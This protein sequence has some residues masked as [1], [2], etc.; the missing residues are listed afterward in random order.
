M[1]LSNGGSR[2]PDVSIATSPN[3]LTSVPAIL[4]QISEQGAHFSTTTL[5]YEGR[6]KLLASARALVQALETP[7]ETMLKHIW[8]QPSVQVGITMLYNAG[9]FHFMAEK[10][11]PV[12]IDECAEATKMDSKLLARL[13]R[14]LG[15]MGYIIE[16]GVDEYAPTN[17]SKAMSLR[18]IGDGYPCVVNGLFNTLGKFGDFTKAHDNKMV[19][20]H[21]DTPLRYTEKTDMN[22]FTWLQSL[23]LGSHLNNHMAGYHQG[24]P[25]WMDSNI[26]P[27]DDRLIKGAD[28][29]EDAPFLVDIGGS[30]GHDLAEFLSKHPGHPGKLIL[31]D[32]P[33]VINHI[34]EL[35]QRIEPVPY[36]FHTT[37]PYQGA[38][39]Y[40][41]HSVLHDWP[42]NICADI[43]KNVVA[44]MAPGYSRLLINE[45]VIP[46]RGADWQATALDVMIMIEFSSAERTLADWT[47]LLEPAGL[48]IIQV[49]GGGHGTESLIECELA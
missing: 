20:S 42:D 40:Y 24:R 35:D 34:Q 31:E 7:R 6:L 32:L 41:M 8:A 37:Q 11:G 23:G 15:A 14:H 13:M 47:R 5:D 36:D 19:L 26:Y 43:L 28:T 49:W 22:V 44:A 27:V 33:V 12:T 21:T 16:T 18:I 45:E 1:T 4:K 39:A 17:F 2:V 3:D 38:R 10:D 9:V 46:D 25:S 48:Q 29:S 30:T